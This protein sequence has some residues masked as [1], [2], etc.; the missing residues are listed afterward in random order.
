MRVTV[1]R[2]PHCDLD[3]L[4]AIARPVK[5]RSTVT[6]H[7]ASFELPIAGIVYNKQGK[8][9]AI[10]AARRHAVGLDPDVRRVVGAR[11]VGIPAALH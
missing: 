2:R 5:T 3:K 7:V 8:Y 1:E 10:A 9:E 11:G 4:D 6:S